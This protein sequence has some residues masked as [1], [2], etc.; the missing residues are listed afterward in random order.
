MNVEDIISIESSDHQ[1]PLGLSVRSE[2]CGLSLAQIENH[3]DR[4]RILLQLRQQPMF[5]ALLWN[6][7][8]LLLLID[9]S[10]SKSQFLC[11]FEID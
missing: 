4:G 2:G 11:A 8:V 1:H 7:F 10:N 6:N 9:G 5:H 3:G